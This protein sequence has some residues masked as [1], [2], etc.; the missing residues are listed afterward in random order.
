MT[1]DWLAVFEA[2]KACYVEEAF[3]NIAI[4]EAVERHRGCSSGFVRAFAKGVIRD[5]MRLDYC[6]EKL[7]D[8]GLKGIKKRT[9]IV[10]RM[11]LYAID[12][13]DSVPDYAAVNEA[14]TLAKK[15]S[16]GTDRFINALLRRYVREKGNLHIPENNLSLRYS[17]PQKL[18]DLLSSQYGED[19][20][21]LVSALNKAPALVLRVN[22]LM[23]EPDELAE[24]LSKEGIECSSVPGSRTALICTKGQP[25]ESEYYRSGWFSVQ[26]LSSI[27]SIEAFGPKAGSR[28]LDMCAAP[29]GKTCALAELMNGEGSITACD[30]Y[31]HRL[32]LIE[33]QADRLGIEIIDTALLD[34]TVHRKEYECSFDY[35]LADVPCSG[36][37]VIGSK[38]ELKLRTD[39]DRYAE[40]QDTQ[41]AILENAFSYLNPGG[42][43]MYSTCTVN[44]H[45]NEGI[46]EAFMGNSPKDGLPEILEKKAIL[47]Y[48]ESLVGFFYC[49]IEKSV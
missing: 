37:G 14:V 36:L 42:R 26:T 20:E 23:A 41:L 49:I 29:G 38:P 18:I 44:R 46:I 25:V 15:V 22:T 27:L 30:V 34:G 5:T 1:G 32:E 8:K 31:P 35:V 16:R 48:N 19:T 40:L 10:I 3:S 12:S 9:L 43:L 45:E 33:A 7:A 47:P 28:V 39:P 17:F 21:K 4:N 13:L 2:L 11:G 24:L 6:V